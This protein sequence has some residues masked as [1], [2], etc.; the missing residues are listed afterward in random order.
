VELTAQPGA[1]QIR[2]SNSYSLAAQV[3]IAGGESWQLAI[4]PDQPE[5]LRRLLEEGLAADLLLVSGGVSAGKHDLV[6]EA[7]SGLG[8][9]FL[10]RGAL[11][12]PG[13]PVVFGRVP[14]S[15]EKTV[16]P[17]FGLPGNPVSTMV[18]FELFAR[19]VL[20]ALSGAPTSPLQ[21]VKARLK[22]EFKTRIGLTRFLPA[23]VSGKLEEA[24]V[25]TV[26]WQGSGDVAATARANCYLVIP[27]EAEKL[28]AGELVS[29]LM[30]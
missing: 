20:D 19:P 18:C 6:E 17:F 29:I 25:E 24:V 9:E 21:F 12:Q 3:E 10:F 11:I 7:L 28:E 30:R 27:P 23:V 1:Y 14:R 5:P 22:S 26:R 2:N 16:T 4:A 13:K 15:G 8:A